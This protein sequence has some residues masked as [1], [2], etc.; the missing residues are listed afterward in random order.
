MTAKAKKILQLV[1]PLLLGLLLILLLY[2]RV[3]F[4]VVR[5]TLREDVDWG[6]IALSCLLGPLS[7]LCRSLRA[8]LLVRH[9]SP[10]RSS[11]LPA[12]I[13]HVQGSYAVNM[14]IPHTGS[15]WRCASLAK[16]AGVGFS[17]LLGAQVAERAVD[18][19]CTLLMLLAGV[20]FYTS[21]F[22]SFVRENVHVGGDSLWILVALLLLVV[23][24]LFILSRTRLWDRM[25]KGWQQFLDGLRTVLRLDRRSLVLFLLY[26][27]AI[28]VSYLMAFYVTF[29]AFSFTQ[30]FGLGVALMIFLLISLTTVLPVQ[31]NIG[32]WHFVVI[33]SLTGLGVS[34]DSSASFALIVHASQNIV[35]ALIGLLSILCLPLLAH[36]NTSPHNR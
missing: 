24:L 11:T 26:S 28:W 19:V 17:R 18:L 29:F 1:L 6:I 34:A 22:S 2:R 36:H 16:Y 20:I 10:A 15:L 32:P 23:L 8:D 31:G 4:D 35:T 33:H 14:V 9:L 5:R 12:T 27:V 25:R 13:L 3:D 21:H 7:V 30:G